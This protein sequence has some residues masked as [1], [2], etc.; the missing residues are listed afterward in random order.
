MAKRDARLQ[1]PMDQQVLDQLHELADELG[2]DSVPAMVRFWAKAEI[3]Q[4]SRPPHLSKPNAI[5]LRY[6][7]MVL[8]LNPRPQSAGTA[9]DYLFQQFRRTKFKEFF[10]GLPQGPTSD[11]ISGT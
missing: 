7:E 8:A 9:F 10:K 11:R 4:H 1:V 6:V 2:F 3:N 5:V